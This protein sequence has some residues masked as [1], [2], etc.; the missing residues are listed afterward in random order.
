MHMIDREL[1]D[2]HE[3]EANLKD[4]WEQ[5]YLTGYRAAINALFSNYM[6]QIKDLEVGV[7]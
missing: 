6:E 5:G 1:N 4:K 2:W 7:E 3:V